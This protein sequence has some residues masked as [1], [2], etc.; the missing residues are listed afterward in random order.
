VWSMLSKVNSL[1]RALI[2]WFWKMSSW[3]RKATATYGI[4]L[5]QDVAT[6]LHGR[7]NSNWL[8]MLPVTLSQGTQMTWRRAL[9]KGPLRKARIWTPTALPVTGRLP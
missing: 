5:C 1:I 8:P 7:T 9:V 2:G 6:P 3:R 4:Q